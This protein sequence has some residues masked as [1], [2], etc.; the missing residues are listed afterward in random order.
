MGTD[1]FCRKR[2]YSQ[3]G[4]SKQAVTVFRAARLLWGTD[5]LTKK[6]AARIAVVAGTKR[7]KNCCTQW[8]TS[9]LYFE[10]SS[11]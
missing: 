2:M 11:G 10:V 6:S 7:I 1:V 3:L 5:G 8:L 9:K 4:I